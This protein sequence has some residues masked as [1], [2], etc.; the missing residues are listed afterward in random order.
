MREGGT[1][2]SWGFQYKCKTVQEPQTRAVLFILGLTLQGEHMEAQVPAHT[3]YGSLAQPVDV[4][5]TVS[6]EP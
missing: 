3:P 4:D 1:V 5:S 2:G 6:E